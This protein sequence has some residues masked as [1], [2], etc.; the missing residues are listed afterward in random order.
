M[1]RM[2]RKKGRRL[3]LRGRI[4]VVCGMCQFGVFVGGSMV[5]CLVACIRW[6]KAQRVGCRY[7]MHHMLPSKSG[8]PRL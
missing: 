6:G 5:G 8:I 1:R 2:E 7:C 3:R 4:E